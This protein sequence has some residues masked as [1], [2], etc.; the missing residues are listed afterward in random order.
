MLEH[1]LVDKAVAEL[2]QIKVHNGLEEARAI[3]RCVLSHFFEGNVEVFREK[4]GRHI[5][6]RK[7]SDRRDL[8][9]S[10]GKL[11]AAVMVTAQLEQ[12]PSDIAW[13]LSFTHH[14]MLLRVKELPTKLLL[15]QTAVERK[16]SSRAFLAVVD[17]HV[18][19]PA[20]AKRGR[21]AMPEVV[22]QLRKASKVF[23][24]DALELAD[25]R[26]L[27]DNFTEDELEDI[28]G[29][30]EAYMDLV[31]SALSEQRGLTSDPVLGPEPAEA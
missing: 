27:L 30:A 6:F 11:Y 19:P 28:L 17:E 24:A 10:Y 29:R 9:Y 23:E 22:K 1:T 8:P 15:A 13:A 7:L 16:L 26:T 3:G 18:Q 12:L 21:P 31:R 4:R 5:S 2:K 14:R 20:G 25:H